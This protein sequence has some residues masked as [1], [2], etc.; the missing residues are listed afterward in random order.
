MNELDPI[1]FEFLKK[2]Q[3]DAVE[4]L[5]PVSLSLRTERFST[6][7]IEKVMRTVERIP[8]EKIKHIVENALVKEQAR[9][10]RLTIKVG[11][12]NNRTDKDILELV[13]ATH[14][15]SIAPEDIPNVLDKPESVV[16]EKFDFKDANQV[17]AFI[18]RVIEMYRLTDGNKDSFMQNPRMYALSVIL[19]THY[20]NEL[21]NPITRISNDYSHFIEFFSGQSIDRSK[22][23]Q[24][25]KYDLLKL[26]EGVEFNV[27][28][29]ARVYDTVNNVTVFLCGVE[30]YT[31]DYLK[32]LRLQN[33]F[34]LSFKPSTMY[35]GLGRF[36]LKGVL[37]HLEVGNYFD[38]AKL[39][40]SIITKLYDEQYQ[41]LW[42]NVDGQNITFE[43]FLNDYQ[44]HNDTIITQVLHCE[45]FD[46]D[47][48]YYIK[49]LDHEFI[50][51]SLDEYEA[52]QNNHLQK[53]N[54]RKRIKT[55][56][57][58]NA[59]IPISND[60]NPLFDFLE[61]KFYNRRLIAEYFQ[62]VLDEEDS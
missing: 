6:D 61:M 15:F 18:D 33:E 44:I 53:G 16:R 50:F 60:T 24:F 36:E 4:P 12:S 28:G 47:G 22:E 39:D 21:R 7:G 62:R 27:A 57:I 25:N 1:I 8:L 9:S 56:K 3:K 46:H 34:E 11:K 30:D 51:Y 38:T 10:L 23:N 37:E 32:E 41:T 42:I 48:S 40:K 13:K 2:L 19:I 14:V 45:Y 20:L 55:F 49:H 31:F 5:N 43:E 17:D 59:K 35:F 52:R 54:A 58:D 29:P 26:H